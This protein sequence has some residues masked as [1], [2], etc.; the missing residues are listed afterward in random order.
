M[1]FFF[2]QQSVSL[3]QEKW[4]RKINNDRYQ[5]LEKCVL[6][7]AKVDDHWW[8]ANPEEV[9]DQYLWVRVCIMKISDDKTKRITMNHP[10]F[11]TK[12]GRKLRRKT[13]VP[14]DESFV[15]VQRLQQSRTIPD[16]SNV[17]M[18]V[19]WYDSQ[20]IENVEYPTEKKN[21]WTTRR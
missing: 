4:I 20:N 16:T 2:R 11:Y 13:I 7:Q 12:I 17:A 1:S 21:K 5:F 19:L 9:E 3:F 18:F 15:D 14:C 8:I 10:L 6:I